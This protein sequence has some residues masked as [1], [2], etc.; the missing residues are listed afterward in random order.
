MAFGSEPAGNGGETLRMSFWDQHDSGSCAVYLD[1]GLIDFLIVERPC[2]P[3]TL[4]IAG[5]EEE[6]C[7]ILVVC[8]KP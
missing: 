5:N 1:I 8:S 6:I 7:S 4:D 2:H 3:D